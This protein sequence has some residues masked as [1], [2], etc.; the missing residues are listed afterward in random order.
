[1]YHSPKKALSRYVASALA[2]ALLLSCAPAKEMTLKEAMQVT[3]SISG[4]TFTPPPR[5]IRDIIAI[6][7]ET[8][9]KESIE[10]KE[11]KRIADLPLPQGA[12]EP[13]LLIFYDARNSALR[14]LGRFAQAF[15]EGKAMLMLAKKLNAS[16]PAVYRNIAASARAEGKHRQAIEFFERVRP[17]S[18]TD[19]SILLAL[20]DHY[21][22]VGDFD[23]ARKRLEEGIG[24]C[25]RYTITGHPRAPWHQGNAETMKA[26]F[27]EA[28]GK[29]AAAEP[30][31]RRAI[32]FYEQFLAFRLTQGV[33]SSISHISARAHLVT[34]LKNQGRLLEAEV[35]CRILLKK[36][37]EHYGKDEVSPYLRLASL[38]EILLRQGKTQ[39]AEEL[40]RM[41]LRTMTELGIPDDSFHFRQARIY[42]GNILT[43]KGEYEEA[44][45]VYGQAMTSTLSTNH[46]L[47]LALI[48]TG[49]LAEAS[50]N[51]TKAYQRDSKFYGEKHYLTAEIMGFRG[52]L[53]HRLKKY[54]AALE[55]FSTALPVLIGPGSDTGA[56]YLKRRLLITILEGYLSLLKEI[57]ENH[58]KVRTTIDPVRESFR[59]VD[60]LMGKSVSSAMAESSARAAVTDKDLAD[61]IRREQDASQEI[62][63]P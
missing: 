6:L 47:I 37:I 50:K 58:V 22:K 42:L 53:N 33:R 48:E 14:R 26:M 40:A 32:L 3:V 44:M 60:I 10:M 45:A 31:R 8:S 27:L 18:R 56:D 39:D 9:H 30:L 57:G 36:S 2:I 35:E 21:L 17:Q 13:E 51:I 52:M 49:R 20:V 5:N 62:T 16:V 24:A 46:N 15:E 63:L 34:N 1:M 61:L 4:N 55:D 41:A 43:G 25:A 59:I 23:M 38:G 11:A 29:F 54:Q 12:S 19:T 28:E 7:E